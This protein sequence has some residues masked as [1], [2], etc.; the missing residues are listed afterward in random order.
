MTKKQQNGFQ[1]LFL[2][3]AALP[4]CGSLQV[5][6]PE[7]TYEVAKGDKITLTCLFTPAR[8]DITMLVLTWEAEPNSPGDPMKPVATYFY[9]RQVDIA[10]AY[11]GRAFMSVDIAKRE[12]S[13]R[14]TQ[15]TIEDSR[16]YQ[17]SVIIPSDD[18][19]TT[20]AI[21]SLLVLEPPSKPICS[22]KGKAEYWNNITLTCMSEEGS[23]KPVYKW[24]SYSVQNI[25][26]QFPPKTTEKEGSLFLFNISME[27]SGFYVC[28]STNQIGFASC[29]FTLAVMPPSMNIGATAGIIGGV[30][31]GLLCGGIIIYCCCCWEKGK[32]DKYAEGSPEAVELHDGDAPEETEYN[33]QT[34]PRTQNLNYEEKGVLH[35]NDYD[36]NRVVAGRKFEDDQHSYDSGKGRIVEAVIA[37]TTGEIIMVVVVIAS[38]TIM[39]MINTE[40]NINNRMIP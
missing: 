21:T 8:P 38:M 28:T 35:Q 20:A 2:I 15:V 16:S 14:L 17:C 23:P 1:K 30:L 4:C 9:E 40:T 24:Q 36:E 29:N 6:I 26:Q 34:N 5:S 18:E 19:G 27:T 7:K 33:S 12:S 37:L 31:A 32:K 25:P 39:I 3:L 10:P 13:L 11:E 22:L